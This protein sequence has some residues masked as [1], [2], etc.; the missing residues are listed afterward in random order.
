MRTIGNAKLGPLVA[1]LAMTLLAVGT[2]H[3]EPVWG[4]NCL[5]CHDVLHADA[6]MIVDYDGISDPFE[7]SGSPDRGP[8]PV[9][10]TSP[11]VTRSLRAEVLGLADDDTY[12]VEIR[13]FRH[14]GVT[15]GGTLSFA[16]DCDWPEWGNA[17]YYTEPYVAYRW[18]AG[19]PVSFHY[20]M[21]LLPDAD[22]DYYDLI[23]AVAG[24]HPGTNELFYCQQHFYL[25]VTS[26]VLGDLNCDGLLTAADIDPFVIAL[27]SGQQQFEQFFPLCNFFNADTNEDGVV[28]AADI[29]PFVVALT[30][31]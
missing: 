24:R 17:S 19:D 15:A 22:W 23:F 4:Q 7:L 3:A 14:N 6:L 26:T 28:T 8:L 16:P 5:A 30:G 10:R 1:G 18:G 13:R 2:G 21:L 11:G 25:Q 12:A 29:D 9:F 20:D 31:G 27:T